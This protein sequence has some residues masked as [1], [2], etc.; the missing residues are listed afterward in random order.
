VLPPDMGHNNFIVGEDL[1]QPLIIFLNHLGQNLITKDK[2]D[3]SSWLKDELFYPTQD[4][5]D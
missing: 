4:I 3:T 5:I 1:L 2:R